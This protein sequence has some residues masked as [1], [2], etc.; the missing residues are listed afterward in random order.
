MKILLYLIAFLIAIFA[1]SLYGFT[2]RVFA[3]VMLGG[4]SFSLWNIASNL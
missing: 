2:W 4:I 1:Q 3:V